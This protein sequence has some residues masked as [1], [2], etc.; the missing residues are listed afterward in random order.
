MVD[1]PDPAMLAPPAIVALKE[2]AVGTK[3]SGYRGAME[4]T[5]SM[6][7]REERED[8]KRAA[9]Q[10]LN[11]IMD[12]NLDGTIRWASPSWK[13]L[14]GADPESIVGKTMSDIIVDHKN[15]FTDVIALMKNDDT[16]SRIIRFA[17]AYQ[18]PV[19]ASPQLTVESPHAEPVAF[20]TDDQDNHEHLVN[21]EAQGIMVYERATGEE[22]H[23]RVLTAS[24][25]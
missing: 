4:R 12:L 7:I 15:I 17:I 19:G 9:E 6:D 10:S 22:S 1:S 13:D 16:K 14:S 3:D 21:L 18:L 25:T 11:A 8:L 20:I 2:D 24:E 23:V 5:V